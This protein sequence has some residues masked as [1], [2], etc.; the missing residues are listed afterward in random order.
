VRPSGALA[1]GPLEDNTESGDTL[2]NFVAPKKA[3]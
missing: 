2:L 3:E 1:L